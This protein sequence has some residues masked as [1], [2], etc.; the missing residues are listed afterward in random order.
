MEPQ[1]GSQ[2]VAELPQSWKNATAASKRSVSHFAQRE[3]DVSFH[4][5]DYACR[6]RDGLSPKGQSAGRQPGARLFRCNPAL[7]SGRSKECPQDARYANCVG[8][9]HEHIEDPFNKQFTAVGNGHPA[10][11]HRLSR[12]VSRLRK[13]ALLT[14]AP[15]GEIPRLNLSAVIAFPVLCSQPP[16]NDGSL[17]KKAAGGSHG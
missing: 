8:G 11:S 5:V 16:S 4:Q 10:Q 2:L 1:S 9:G 12:R 17:A 6:R 7:R 14:G 13:R 3:L 15:A